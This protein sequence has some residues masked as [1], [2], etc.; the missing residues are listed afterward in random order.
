M[1]RMS[2]ACH[3]GCLSANTFISLLSLILNFF[4][5]ITVSDT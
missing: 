5:L 2:L 1:L 4:F 3:H